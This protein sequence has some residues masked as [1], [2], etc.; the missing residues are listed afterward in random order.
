MNLWFQF[1]S[2]IS[3]LAGL[4]AAALWAFA[5]WK[6]HLFAPTRATLIGLIGGLVELVTW[7][8]YGMI[9]VIGMLPMGG[10]NS[11]IYQVYSIPH[12]WDILWMVSTLALGATFLSLA[13]TLHRGIRPPE[14]PGS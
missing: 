2:S 9:W 8:F 13:W 7:F 3:S 14:V 10:L 4:L 1:T 12:L 6:L 11:M 5:F